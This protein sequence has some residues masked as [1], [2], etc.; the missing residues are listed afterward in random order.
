MSGDHR[1]GNLYERGKELELS[2][3][4]RRIRLQSVRVENAR[5]EHYLDDREPLAFVYDGLSLVA[6]LFSE[7]PVRD[8]E[9]ESGYDVSLTKQGQYALGRKTP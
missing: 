3:G 4:D 9:E 6:I 8:F 7:G 2:I 1:S 5:G